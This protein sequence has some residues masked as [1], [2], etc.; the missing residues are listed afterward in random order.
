M[1]PRTLLT[2]TPTGITTFSSSVENAVIFNQNSFMAV[3]EASHGTSSYGFPQWHFLEFGDSTSGTSAVFDSN[4]TGASDVNSASFQFYNTVTSGNFHPYAGSFSV[5]AIPDDT[6][7]GLANSGL[8]R[9]QAGQVGAAALGT[10]SGG[11]ATIGITGTA[12]DWLIGTFSITTALPLGYSTFTGSTTGSTASGTGTAGSAAVLGSMARA[13]IAADLNNHT[14]LRFAVVANDTA[15]AADWE[16]N[17]T[18]NQPQLTLDINQAPAVYFDATTFASESTAG[19]GITTPASSG[20]Y[21]VPE[22]DQVPGNTTTATI[23]INRTTSASVTTK[24][25]WA[26]TDGTAHFANGDYIGPTSGDVTFNPGDTTMP[27]T[28]TFSNITTTDAFRTVNL[29]LTDPGQTGGD[30]APVFP[31]AGNTATVRIN[32]LQAVNVVVDSASYSVNEA[33]GTATFTASRSGSGVGSLA[34]DVSFS[35]ADGLAYSS[36]PTQ[37]QNALAGRDY[38]IAGATTPTTGMLHWNA[39]DSSSKSFTVPL[40]DVKTFT[41]TR[42][43]AIALSNPS[44]GS[45]LGAVSQAT[46]T[47]NDNTVTNSDAPMGITTHSSG[48]ETSGPFSVNSFIALA[49]APHGSQGFADMPVITFGA[50]S[51][52]FPTSYATATVDS[53]RLSIY[54]TATTGGFGGAPGSFDV[55]LL[56]D[57]SVDDSALRYQGGTGATG[58]I[59][60]GTQ[61]SPL[62][63]GTASFPNNQVGYN[64]YTFD[65]LSSD[66]RAAIAS[67]LNSSGTSPIRFAITPSSGSTVFADWEGN[68]TVNQPKLSVLVEKSTAVLESFK[69]DVSSATV[70][71]AAGTITVQVDRSS[72][73]DLSDEADI[74]YATHDGTAGMVVGAPY[75]GS[76]GVDGTDYTGVTG[77]AHFNAGE[78]HTTFTISILDNPAIYGDKNFTVTIDSPSVTGPGRAANVVLPT[79]ESIT[80]LDSRTVDLFQNGSDNATVRPDGPRTGASG[81]TYINIENAGAG[82]NASYGVIDFNVAG[83]LPFSPPSPVGTINQI[84]LSTVT[85]F[86]VSSFQHNGTFR[87]YLVDDSTTDIQPGTAQSTCWARLATAPGNRSTFFLRSR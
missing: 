66:V 47:I 83:V 30:P 42:T 81:K 11:P 43:F 55:Y 65:N 80:I 59:V 27:I 87:V 25:H 13:T 79:T 64:E 16:G 68:F 12:N 9:N 48:V 15:F 33:D 37:E 58:P 21:F 36:S 41:G 45:A 54:N 85:G 70:D 69:L 18:R 57:N 5:Y 51:S 82:T 6:I 73:G 3:L 31:N 56:T 75:N 62:L 17:F 28:V 35:T 86:P 4:N 1:E 10:T 22:T 34:T 46:V 14:P 72:S 32:Y 77:T 52:V 60:I 20:T 49:S 44:V 26:I 39:G 67:D 7:S 78:D 24:V 2:A 29:T 23:N 40:L 8:F 53:V 76:I 19:L 84:T 74:H 38:G 71:K 50:G 63:L 61:A